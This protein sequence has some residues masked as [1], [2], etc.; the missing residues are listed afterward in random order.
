[1]AKHQQK[2]IRIQDYEPFIGAEAVERIAK[3][4]RA[5]RGLRVAHV[6]STHSGGGVAEILSSL[7]LLMNSAG[8]NTEWRVME[9]TPEFFNVT[10]KIH[11]ALQGGSEALSEAEK[12]VYE[13]VVRENAIRNELDH[14]AVLVH[15]PQPLPLVTHYEKQGPWLWQCHIDLT[16]PNHEVLDYLRPFIE[17]YSGAIFSLPEYA[18]PLGIPQSFIMPAID[19][20]VAKNAPM[21]DEEVQDCLDQ[22]NIPTDLPLVVQISR[23]DKWK[24]PLGVIEAFK[25]AHKDVEATLVLLGSSATDDPEGE[26]IY[27]SLLNH[28][29]ERILLLSH[30]DSR[31]VNAL[32]RRAAVVLQ[33]SLREGFGLTVS[34]A[35]W[36]GTPVIGGKAG[37]IPKQIKDGYNG[38][39]VNSV[40][41]AAERIVLLL[42]NPDVCAEMGR[43]AHETVKE[44]F[45]LI[46]LFEQYLDLLGTCEPAIAAHPVASPAVAAHS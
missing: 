5:F 14:D 9:G 30:E 15:D 26:A 40:E 12:E 7:T 13:Q 25:L 29:E 6:N 3:K 22:A 11:N 33:K 19:P 43:K 41:E 18:Q 44:H 20:F 37:G 46:R 42:Q 4:A 32:Q 31:L 17:Q 39:I 21:S 8:L 45:L 38:F 16:T 23:F 36:K 2:M 34:E 24:D 28:A 1:M 35:M 10:K 27:H